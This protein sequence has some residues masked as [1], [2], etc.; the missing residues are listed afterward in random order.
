MEANPSE[1]NSSSICIMNKMQAECRERTHASYPTPY[2]SL[3]VILPL[4]L[5]KYA[6]RSRSLS[7]IRDRA[8]DTAEVEGFFE[9][10]QGEIAKL[11]VRSLP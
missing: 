3:T 1:P 11:I 9:C 5:E 2:Q 6:W 10:G 8:P 4:V 7:P